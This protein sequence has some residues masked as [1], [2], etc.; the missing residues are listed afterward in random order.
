VIVGIQTLNLNTRRN[1]DL[2]SNRLDNLARTVKINQ[3]LVN[4]HL[5]PIPSLG[6]LAIQSPVSRGSEMGQN[7]GTVLDVFD[8]A[9]SQGE[10]DLA[11]FECGF[12]TFSIFEDY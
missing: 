10:A 3:S 4:P 7:V 2:S 1:I 11:G 9:G 12:K 8:V 5:I 6:P